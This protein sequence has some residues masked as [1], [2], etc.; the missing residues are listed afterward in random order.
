MVQPYGCMKVLSSGS[1]R[2]ASRP[3]RRDGLTPDLD[4]W[5]RFHGT[6]SSGRA[7]V[8]RHTL[9][10]VASFAGVSKATA[11][12]VLNGSVQVDPETRQR[13]L[14][15]MAELD[16]TPS[17]AARR[18]SFGR[19]LTISVVTSFLTRPQAA[20]RLRGVDAVLS[21]S[22]F[23]LV[24]YNVETVEKRDQY[25]RGLALAQ[26]TD[27]LLVISLPPREEDV[28]RLSSAAIPVVVDR[29][30]CARR[31]RGCPHVVGDDI[32]GGERRPATC[33]SSATDASRSSA[34]SSTTRS[35]SRPAA[36]ASGLR[37]GLRCGRPR[38]RARARR[39]RRAQPLRGPRAGRRAAAPHAIGRPPS[40]PPATPRRWAS[41]AAAREAGLHVPEDLSVVG[42]D[43]IEVADYVGLTHRA[44]A[45]LRVRP[46]R[47]R[48]A[49]RRD[50][51]AIRRRRLSSSCLPRSWSA[52][53]RRHRRRAEHCADPRCALP[54]R[55]DAWR[56]SDRDR[57][58]EVASARVGARARDRRARRRR[59]RGRA[60]RRPRSS[61][62][63]S[64]TAAGPSCG[65]EPVELLAYFETGFPFA[66]ALADEFTKQFPNVT[67]NIRE[68]Q[69]ANLMPQTPRLLV[70]R[71]PARPHPAAHRWSPWSRTACS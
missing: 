59:C 35:A 10:D 6:G 1:V 44:P 26:R 21:D 37:A 48:A 52:A 20:E 27:G 19:T 65:T 64:V 16:Y 12:R 4:S 15:A 33:S 32:A 43:D 60:G 47:R 13:V 3:A 22:E 7:S 58:I 54:R 51:G 11:S 29:R 17:S 38:A 68:D 56:R 5:Y 14:A 61:P 62:A 49:A 66:K 63:A 30:P 71:Q 28:R 69:F 45:A 2:G 34:T 53:P 55:Q 50:P 40:S 42:Y 18:L 46:H 57:R 8:T 24:I 67:W 23:D 36:I 39:P 9:R 41:S 25:L 31:S 70:E